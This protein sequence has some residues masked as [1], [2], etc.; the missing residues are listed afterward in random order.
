MRRW[1]APLLVTLLASVAAGAAGDAASR[2]VPAGTWGGLHAVLEVE[3][4]GARIEYDCAH[5]T[6]DGALALD[7]EGRFA[8]AGSHTSERG[9]PVHEG[10]EP[11][12]RPAR[13]TGSLRGDTLTLTLALD[14]ETVGT[15]TLKR[16]ENGRLVKCQ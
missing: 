1:A 8:V 5:G 11:P 6:L 4:Q 14:G 12:S 13:Y 16:G 9:G 2:H 10:Q 7:A 3:E 15:F